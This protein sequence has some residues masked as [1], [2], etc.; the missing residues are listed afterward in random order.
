MPLLVSGAVLAVIQLGWPGP[1]W[2]SPY[3][4]ILATKL[5]LAAILFGLASWNRWVLTVPATNGDLAARTHMRWS[6]MGEMVLAI[7]ILGL[8]SGWRFTPPP[9]SLVTI[10][11]AVAATLVLE[12]DGVTAEVTIAPPGR[13]SRGA[14]ITLH[15]IG[16]SPLAAR[17]VVLSLAQPELGIQ[18]IKTDAVL[19]GEGTW[20]IEQLLIPVAGQWAVEVQVRVSDFKLVRLKGSLEI[21]P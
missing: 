8:A 11:E 21:A 9:R 20:S 10:E 15:Q 12:G 13:A 16:G 5:L 18:P 7:A 2:A 1:A 19:T 17:S 3:G 14:L 4:I 6:I